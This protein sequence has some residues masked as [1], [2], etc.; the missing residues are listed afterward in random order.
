MCTGR[1]EG[2]HLIEKSKTKKYFFTNKL[3]PFYMV[4]IL[5]NR[6]TRVELHWTLSNRLH[7]DI[8]VYSSVRT[9]KCAVAHSEN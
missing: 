7:V 1:G 4:Y 5:K 2:K 8:A 3:Y 6:C 9:N